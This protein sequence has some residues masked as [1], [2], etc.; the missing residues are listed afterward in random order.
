MH[1]SPQTNPTFGT[2]IGGDT[3]ALLRRTWRRPRPCLLLGGV[4]DSTSSDPTSFK[5][6]ICTIII[7]KIGFCRDLGCED[8]IV[9]KTNK[10]SSLVA[11]LKKYWEKVDLVAF[12]IWHAGT[13]L[14]TTLTHLTAAFSTV[15]PRVEP[16]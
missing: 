12:P 11:A 5:K 3:G 1:C 8:K 7:V 16:T 10:Y 13:T 6:K 4:P 2:L 15:R 9:A 14:T